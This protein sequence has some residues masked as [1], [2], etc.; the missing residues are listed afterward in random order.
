[1]R[2]A[3]AAL[4]QPGVDRATLLM[5]TPANK[6]ALAEAGPLPAAVDAARANDVLIVVDAHTADALVAAGATIERMLQGEAMPNTG[7]SGAETIPRSL[8]MQR[9]HAQR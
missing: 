3:Q 9:A 2:I 5:G 6:A 1:M 7:A 8:A 4:A